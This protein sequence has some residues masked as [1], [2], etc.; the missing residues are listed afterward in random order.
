MKHW[1][2]A[3]ERVFTIFGIPVHILDPTVPLQPYELE[4]LPDDA[5]VFWDWLV[6][7]KGYD[8]PAIM[9]RA[10]KQSMGLCSYWRWRLNAV[11]DRQRGA[12]VVRYLRLTVAVTNSEANA[13]AEMQT[14]LDGINWSPMQSAS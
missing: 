12:T 6:E 9:R 10:I 4:G 2:D 8:A 1:N 11:V 14:S 5:L 3:Q 13:L 7:Q